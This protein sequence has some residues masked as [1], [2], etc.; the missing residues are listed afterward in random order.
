MPEA[1]QVLIE[2][3]DAVRLRVGE[4]ESEFSSG[5]ISDQQRIRELGLE[6]ASKKAILE[7]GDVYTSLADQL[8]STRELM[9][10]SDAE[11]AAMARAELPEIEQ[12]LAQAE[13]NLIR[14]LRPPDPNDGRACF[15]EVRAGT[16]GDEAALF[17][18]DLYRMYVIYAG[19][20]GWRVSEMSRNETGLQGLKEVI[21]RIEGPEVWSDLKFETGVHR[22]QRVPK[23]E[24]SGR[25]HTS[26]CTVA[27]IPE[28]PES[29]INIR[30][31]DLKIDVYRSSGAGGQH[32]NTTDSAVRITHLP[33]GVIVQCQSE[34]S[35]IKNR[36]Q[37]MGMLAAR[38]Q[39]KQETD[40]AQ[41][42]SSMRKKQVGSGDRSQRIRTY[43]FPQ[44]RVTDHRIGLTL[45]KLQAIMDGD[46]H[47]VV[48]AL[49]S[50]EARE[51][52]GQ[53]IAVPQSG[54][55]LDD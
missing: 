25:I 31:E 17:A 32:V 52:L 34:R 40:A 7:L 22:V 18:A 49:V 38:L 53:A 21:V 1:N 10:D 23:T 5:T 54:A 28:V 47:E 46:L 2:R 51:A 37:A 16:G 41:A 11:L 45:Y 14:H 6:L 50:A 24:A 35:Q 48:E 3:I 12:K 33:T 9:A 26:A 8:S 13:E 29:E 42:Q 15:L 20:R 39:E 27:L 4:I 19:K 30:T 36:A 44:S 55:D 43:N